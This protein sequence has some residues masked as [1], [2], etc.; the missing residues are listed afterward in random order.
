[1]AAGVN[2]K[3]GVSG[4]AQFKQ[5]MKDSQAAVKNLSQQ[6]ALNEEQ[7][8]KNGN[9]QM[10]LQNKTGLLT[11]QIEEQK[12]VV[13]QAE[14]ALNAMRRNGVQQSS[15]AFQ[16]MQAQVMKAATDLTRM[17]TELENVGSA[18]EEAQQGVS[19]MNDALT[20]IDKG[21]RFQNITAGIEKITG[22]LE[23]AAKSAWRMGRQIV[24]ST[25][26]AGS[27]ADD[28]STRAKSYGMSTDQL[29]RMEKT[30]DLI[31]TSVETII[32]A[33]K[34]LRKGIGSAD[35][36][37][38][39]AFAALIGE[40]YNPDD[41]GW[42][43]A[44]W[45]AGEAIMKFS[46]AEEQEVYAQKLFGRSWNELIPLFD[47]GKETYD[48]TMASWST[49]SDENLEKLQKMDDQ[50]QKLQND[51]DTLK[52][53][54]LA[55]VAE[56]LTPAME[57][58]TGLMEQFNAY[59]ETPEGK[60]MMEALGDSLSGLL[61]DLTNIDP[62]TVL[63]G[64]TEVFEKVT[65]GL[66]WFIDNKDGVVNALKGIAVGFGLLKI[67]ELAA[68]IG[69]IVSGL[70]GLPIGGGGGG[71]DTVTG[72]G[73]D[74]TVEPA[75]GKK[76]TWL[77]NILEGL[78]NGLGYTAVLRQHELLMQKYKDEL[79]GLTVEQQQTKASAQM[80]GMSEEE[81]KAWKDNPL[82]WT[83]RG[84]SFDVPGTDKEPVHV[85]TDEQ[86]WM[87]SYM[88]DLTNPMNRMTEVAGETSD[89]LA[90][91]QQSNADMTQAAKDLSAMPE[92]MGTV[93][94]AAVKDGMSQVT[95]V[96]GADAVQAISD[97]IA[98]G[99]GGRVFNMVK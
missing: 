36:G 83:G 13:K 24:Q 47:A 7:L 57:T 73:T 46:D 69:R 68:N 79:G 17:Q 31:D 88:T 4:V 55:T 87:P 12:N 99:W 10:Y 97:R 80:L 49:V 15:A 89:G 64:I 54:F 61:T 81:Y 50:Y 85:V 86:N 59:L 3:M 53:N 43:D 27:W 77:T 41:A 56:A 75:G 82:S 28:L 16:N 45:R 14:N 26:G 30:A 60:K 20:S 35:E 6:L 33:Q 8:K 5:G 29:Q 37:V 44:F 72:N 67:T 91:V 51:F 90:G 1:M 92:T 65:G 48:E 18:G 34:K 40:G 98:A 62:A 76:P 95:I 19:G 71:T 63:G 32:A 52:M 9:E 21:V 39:G 84:H 66:Q 42:E 22:K 23:A 96:L 25:L 94:E 38:M 70:K 11:K 74:T 58:L 93:M 78:S 2:V